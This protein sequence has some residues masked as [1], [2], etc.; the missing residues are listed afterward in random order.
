[1]K[2]NEIISFTF[3]IRKAKCANIC[4]P[5]KWDA[6][7][8][9]C[10]EN[11]NIRTKGRY[12]NGRPLSLSLCCCYCCCQ[13][14]LWMCGSKFNSKTL[15]AIESILT[16]T[17]TQSRHK[18]TLSLSLSLS[19]SLS[20]LLKVSKLIWMERERQSDNTTSNVE[21][22]KLFRFSFVF[23]LWR[24]ISESDRFEIEISSHLNGPTKWINSH[25]HTN[26]AKF[27]G[28]SFMIRL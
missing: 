8:P 1:M 21:K 4:M 13:T 6:C 12:G 5:G 7:K 10:Q 28:F 9:R 27:C 22:R 24:E 11:K 16:A 19:P 23:T 14:T 26:T 17:V 3:R 20:Q 18:L 25:T 15:T 2:W